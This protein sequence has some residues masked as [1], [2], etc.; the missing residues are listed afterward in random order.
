MACLGADSLVVVDASGPGKLST[1]GYAIDPDAFGN[2]HGFAYD[3]T[4]GTA[5]VTSY[6][7]HS[8]ARVDARDPTDIRVR[9]RVV[10]ETAL[11]WAAHASFDARNGL[12]YARPR[13]DVPEKSRRTGGAAA[14]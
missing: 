13:P 1:L 11:A 5:Y 6:S 10:D 4:S 2:A 7:H 3:G 8:L 14:A 9:G 12:V